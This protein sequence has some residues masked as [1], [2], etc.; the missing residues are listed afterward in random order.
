MILFLKECHNHE[1]LTEKS[2]NICEDAKQVILECLRISRAI[3]VN[4]ILD[5][6]QSKGIQVPLARHVYNFI[7]RERI[8]I[9]GKTSWTLGEL[10]YWA[11]TNNKIP[12][13]P[14][15]AFVV[16]LNFYF[17]EDKMYFGD[18]EKKN[19]E[20]G[21]LFRFMLSSRRLL[22]AIIFGKVLHADTT[23]KLMW[24]LY[25]VF[26]FGI[27]DA[28]RRFFPIGI[29]VC[30]FER[31]NDFKFMFDSIQIGMLYLKY[32]IFYIFHIL[33]FQKVEIG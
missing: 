27:M 25:P 33:S 21:D 6:I 32:S 14:D 1:E 29:A 10:A 20:K 18:E 5:N 17:E 11:Y 9:Y 7:A 4:D 28:H 2:V 13:D 26:V 24:N 19:Y 22:E 3:S 23:Y 16:A 30:S 31:K 12:D 8:K 15:E